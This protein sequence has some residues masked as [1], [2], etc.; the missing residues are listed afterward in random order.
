MVDRIPERRRLE[1]PSPINEIKA[2]EEAIIGQTE[3]VDS[4]SRLLVTLRSGIKPINPQPLDVKFLAGPSGVGKTEIVYRLAELL[5]G[6]PNARSKVI[7]LNGAEYK[8]KAEVARLVGAPPGYI[9]SEDPRFPGGTKPVLGQ[10]SLDSHKITFIDR[11]GKQ[12][13]VV[14]ILLDEAEKADPSLHQAFLSILDKGNLDLANNTSSNF[15]NTVVFFT[16][17]IGGQQVERLRDV[18]QKE[19]ETQGIPEAFRETTGEALAGSEAK[20]TVVEAFK[21]AFPPEFRGRI[22]DLVIFRNLNEIAIAKIVGLKIAELQH[23]FTVNGVPIKVELDA[24]AGAYLV[25]NGYNP[26]EG[27]R[28]LEKLVQA[29][30]R[31][32]LTLAHSSLGLANKTIYIE[33]DEQTGELVFYFDEN[34]DLAQS[35]TQ[36]IHPIPRPEPKNEATIVSEKPSAQADESPT[37]EQKPANSEQHIVPQI[38]NSV[39]EELL[40]QYTNYGIDSFQRARD[41]FVKDGLLVDAKDANL[42]P[43]VIKHAANELLNQFRQHGLDAFLSY[44]NKLASVGIFSVTNINNWSA[45]KEFAATELKRQLKSYGH[46]SFVSFRDKLVE[47]GIGTVEEWNKLL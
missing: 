11:N 41:M 35:K 44:R 27:V 17:N 38:P 47:F 39:K 5:G 12:S 7:K 9:G 2:F 29:E 6:N 42:Q 40:R 25:R 18:A 30:I 45:T 24:R 26:S 32:Q 10:E 14:I 23:E 46:K 20:E 16:S 4:F 34:L 31:N 22:K 43:E 1:I 37:K 28:A 15:R 3:A 36:P 19:M 21:M 13:D 33:Q 8:S